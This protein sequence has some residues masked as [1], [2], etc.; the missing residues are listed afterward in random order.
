VG[1]VAHAIR[2]DMKNWKVL[3]GLGGAC[4]MCCSVPLAGMFAALAGGASGALA[5]YPGGILPAA[6]IAAA[7]VLA[8]AGI[9]AWQ[10]RRRATQQD[11][12]SCGC[13]V[14]QQ[15]ATSTC[16]QRSC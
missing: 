1:D 2:V 8:G 13:S 7:A 12:G 3:L 5:V 10:K 4:A 14:R 11:G 9:V 6:G 15:D 16:S